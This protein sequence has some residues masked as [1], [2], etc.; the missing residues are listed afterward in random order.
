MIIKTEIA[1][2]VCG[3][4]DW[5]PPWGFDGKT[6]LFEYC[7]CCAVEHG[8]QDCSPAGAKQY[9]EQWLSS[10]AKWDMPEHRPKDWDLS[11]Q[12]ARIDE[13]YR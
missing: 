2:R 9:R 13:K 5:P 10:G 3:Y 7:P 12:L 4:E 1:C 6:P 8:Y 11:E